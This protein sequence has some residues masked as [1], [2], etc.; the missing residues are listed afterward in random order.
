MGIYW[1][2]K[3][4]FQVQYT[5]RSSMNNMLIT[6][7]NVL[8]EK[9]GYVKLF[10]GEIKKSLFEGFKNRNLD[11]IFMKYIFYGSQHYSI[12]GSSEPRI[13]PLLL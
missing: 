4:I 8:F 5:L 12:H 2:V 7:T 11:F 3:G 13:F 6:M 1:E 9:K 10:N